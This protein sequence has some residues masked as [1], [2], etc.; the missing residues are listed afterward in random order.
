MAGELM[1]TDQPRLTGP[2]AASALL[3]LGGASIAAGVIARRRPVVGM[4]ERLQADRRAVSR[5]R[6]LRRQFGSGPVELAIPGRRIV[7]I[8]DPEHVGSVLESTPDP[9]HPASWEKRRALEKFQPHAVLISDGETRSKRRTLNEAALDTDADTHHLAD[10]FLTIIAE[11]SDILAKAAISAGSLDSAM[12]TRTWWRSVRRMVLGDKAR[13]DDAVTDDLW[14][15]REAANWS[16]LGLPHT[17]LRE[18]FF[19]RLYHY[20]EIGDSRS[21]IGSLARI[22]ATGALD[23]IGQVPHWLF[24][25]DAAGMAM[26]RAAALLSTHPHILD[27]CE[28]EAAEEARLR[29]VLRATMLESVRLWPTT[30]A[31]LRELT[32]DHSFAP[33]GARFRAGSSVLVVAPAFHRD[34]D[35]PFA[36]TF[37]PDIWLDGRARSLPQLVPFSSGPAECP[38]RNLVLLT[39]STALAQLFSALDLQLDSSPALDPQAPLPLTLNQF[40]VRFTA[41]PVAQ[42]ATS[43]LP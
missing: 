4:L 7:V 18:R 13:D 11:E 9:F 10:A 26:A 25:F 17:R 39:T 2:A 40:G 19:E 32:T 42:P 14:R 21:L 5:I 43:P 15:L 6:S 3:D 35:L 1:M 16:F 31:I 28:T 24:A 34:P 27:R 12:L 38:G 8:L 37:E 20:A 29:P 41:R 36:D 22:P 30:P 23:P 33:G